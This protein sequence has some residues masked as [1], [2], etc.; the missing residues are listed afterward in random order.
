[1]EGNQPRATPPTQIT[2]DNLPTEFEPKTLT[3]WQNV[4]LTIKVL[5]AVA[6][7]SLL[8]GLFNEQRAE[9]ADEQREQQQ[10][11]SK[12]DLKIVPAEADDVDG[13]AG[14]PD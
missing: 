1:M 12:L 10:L 3:P 7:V 8:C 11:P 4:I 9:A 14:D 13:R 6:L 5:G 2:E